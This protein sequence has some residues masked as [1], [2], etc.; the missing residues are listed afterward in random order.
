VSAAAPTTLAAL[1][2]W[3]AHVISDRDSVAAGVASACAA[4]LGAANSTTRLIRPGQRMSPVEQLAVYQ[5]AYHARLIDCLLDDYPALAHALGNAFNA[6]CHA[7]I[8]R[9][10]SHAPSLN[11]FGQH[12]AQFCAEQATSQ[13][14]FNAELARLEWAIVEVI[15]ADDGAAIELT[16][17]AA[18]SPDAWGR[19][20][21]TPSP[22]LRLLETRYPINA[23]YQAFREQTAATL[24]AAQRAF[25][26]VRRRGPQVIR[27]PLT[28]HSSELLGRLLRGDA[29]G[30][31]L[32]SAAESGMT[33]EQVGACF[34]HWIGSGCFV[35]MRPSS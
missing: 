4:G 24:P 16:T 32:E 3:F 6:L 31:A 20:A 8:A 27:E 7:Y 9:F 26:L 15:H 25:T 10:P 21:L 22:A 5:H 33:P 2:H 34:E 14:V 23:Y 12:M 1:Q 17:L 13:A 18:L 35:A 28:Q 19:V 29:V 30:R 11:Q